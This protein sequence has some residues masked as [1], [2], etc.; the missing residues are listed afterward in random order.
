MS[1]R[2]HRHEHYLQSKLRSAGPE[3]ERQA[4]PPALAST[5]AVVLHVAFAF[6]NRVETGTEDLPAAAAGKGWVK[7]NRR[8]STEVG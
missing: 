4:R 8:E 3:L 2:S 1:P 7:M 6:E 5:L